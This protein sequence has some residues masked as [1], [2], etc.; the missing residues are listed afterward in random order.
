MSCAGVSLFGCG[1]VLFLLAFLQWN[2]N[3]KVKQSAQ[4]PSPCME[5]HPGIIITVSKFTLLSDIQAG[6]LL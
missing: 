4:L 6:C 2:V 1:G 5:L 3:C